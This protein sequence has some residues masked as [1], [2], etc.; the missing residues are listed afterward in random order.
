MNAT[1]R[2]AFTAAT[3]TVMIAVVGGFVLL[4]SPGKQRQLEAD[5]R[6]VQDLHGIAQ[7][8]YNRRRDWL[9]LESEPFMLPTTLSAQAPRDPL[10]DAPYEYRP[11]EAAGRYQLCAEFA[12]PSP[13][14]SR[15]RFWEHPE[16]RHC[17]DLDV[18]E[19]PPFPRS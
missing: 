11:L 7:K 1:D 17:F 13:D 2:I 19:D 10:T 4:G 14:T 8:F 3:S 6:R 5:R 12:L 15:D 18:T 16:G 9:E